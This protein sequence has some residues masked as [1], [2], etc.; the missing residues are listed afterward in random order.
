M[1]AYF[2]KRLLF[3]IPTL[4]IISLFSFLLSLLAPGDQTDQLMHLGDAFLNEASYAKEYQR[5]AQ[6]TRADLPVFYFSILPANIPSDLRKDYLIK[7]DRKAILHHLYEGRT[8]KAVQAWDAALNDQIKKLREEDA[9]EVAG[10]RP[11]DLLYSI[12]SETNEQTI[13]EKLDLL[14]TK[15]SGVIDTD[16]LKLSFEELKDEK[17]SG[18]MRPALYWYGSKNQFHYW[19]KDFFSPSSN[20]SLKDGRLVVRKISASLYWTV[21]MLISALLLSLAIS[22]PMGVYSAYYP[23]R[24]W[25]KRFEQISFALY[26]IPVFWLATILILLF[27]TPY[28]GM[29][30]FP[31]LGLFNASG[32]GS[33]VGQFF[34]VF[35]LLILPIFILSLHA[36]AFVSRQI[37]LSMQK[38]IEQ[39][40]FTAAI[41]KGLSV[42]R[43]LW[44]HAFPNAS[45]PLITLITGS[46]PSLI[47]GTLIIEV[48]F[49]IPGMGRLMYDS[50]LGKDWPVVFAVVNLSGIITVFSYFLADIAYMYI[51]PR[52]RIQ[53]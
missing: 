27:A 30:L 31:S 36:L 16:E 42:N 22:V 7:K 35:H 20:V 32:S 13:Q 28:Y 46:I 23:Q 34:S 52:I 17:G 25:A 48:I 2:I 39:A 51:D 26:S 24:W 6:Q 33:F 15:F 3:F 44:R 37:K 43:A 18:F 4:F 38:E 11:E 19:L 41:A 14:E 45:L 9:K 53:A 10:Q 8:Y 5:I 1:L 12:K 49:N 50:I 40:Y 47:A 21:F 29:K